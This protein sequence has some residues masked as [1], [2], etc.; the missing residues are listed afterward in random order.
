MRSFAFLLATAVVIAAPAQ[1]DEVEG[2]IN[3]DQRKVQITHVYAREVIRMPEDLYNKRTIRILFA[4]HALDGAVVRSERA[5]REASEAG[6]IN[7]FQ[8]EVELPGNEIA[9]FSIGHPQGSGTQISG[10]LRDTF[11]LSGFSTAGG[12]ISGRLRMP[13]PHEFF[14]LP[15]VDNPVQAFNINVRFQTTL[16][17]APKSYLILTGAAALASPQAQRV[18]AQYALLLSGIP[19]KIRAG[20]DPDH[21]LASYFA[22]DAGGRTMLKQLR[23]IGVLAPLP[24]FRASI[25][26]VE[27]RGDRAW[28]LAA[29]KDATKNT[30]TNYNYTL[31]RSDGLWKIGPSVPFAD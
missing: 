2:T 18:L 9:G 19:A 22:T 16:I 8:L 29:T 23:E 1:A 20:L 30:S 28:L 21:P 13:Q 26:R 17:P 27:V 14:P 12:V 6:K 31:Y 4:D 5:F 15:E 3:Y 24:A 11:E 7:G 10:N 25:R